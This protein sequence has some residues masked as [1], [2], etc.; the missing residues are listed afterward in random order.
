MASVGVLSIVR[1]LTANSDLTSAVT[2]S[3]TLGFAVPIGLAGLAGI[4][5]ERAG[6]V[7]IG[8]EGMMILGTFGAGW[9]G[10]Q[11]GA[12][13]GVLAGV[14][15][16]ALGGLLLAVACVS[17]GVD[18][19]IAGTAINL[20]ATGLTKFL[21]ILLFTN[22]PGGGQAQSPPI[23]GT[24]TSITFDPIAQPL[25]A[26]H[27]KNI[28]FV[29][30]LA[31]LIS[32]LFFRLSILS[33]ITFLLFAFTAWLFW[34]TRFGLRLRSAGENPWAADSLGVN[35]VRYKYIAV[36]FSGFLAGLGGAYLSIASTIYRNGN[37]AGRGFI[38]L[39]TM[40]FG[41]WRPGGTGVGALMFGYID[42]LRLID[43]GNNNVRGLILIG[44]LALLIIGASL[45]RGARR[46]SGIG[47]AILG[48][49]MF[50]AYLVASNFPPEVAQVAPYITTLL[51]LAT[52]SQNLRPPTADGV[53]YRKGEGH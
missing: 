22:A 26:L 24:I 3:Q 51:V 31:G 20:L 52:A 50:G 23:K 8:L 2:I 34:K 12:W 41:N 15:F 25:I 40:I 4:W 19:I 44:A 6:V 47:F 18:Q 32:G 30:D 14:I 46:A 49:V 1:T 16:G 27:D 21:A 13:A 10:W 35:V 7:N 9:A 17:F 28:F 39:A 5:S 36:I 29:S 45:L 42:T 37:T 48:S 38:G 43:T 33:V 53:P 11:W